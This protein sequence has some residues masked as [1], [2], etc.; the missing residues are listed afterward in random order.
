MAHA[1]ISAA[2]YRALRQRRQ[3]LARTADTIAWLAKRL[4]A[5]T[6]NS[7]DV[8]EQAA[9]RAEYVAEQEAW[10]ADWQQKNPGVDFE[11]YNEELRQKWIALHPRAG[12]P[13]Y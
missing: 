4:A 12:L 8:A 9:R 3:R 11:Q 13:G 10:F 7:R 5:D 2:Q 1:K 6:A